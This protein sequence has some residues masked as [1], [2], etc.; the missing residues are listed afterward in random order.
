M[1]PIEREV[2]R[3]SRLE[4]CAVC[5]STEMLRSRERD[6]RDALTGSRQNPFRARIYSLAGFASTTQFPV[7]VASATPRYLCKVRRFAL[8]KEIQNQWLTR[9]ALNLRSAEVWRQTGR[10]REF[11][12]LTGSTQCGGLCA[13]RRGYSRF[14]CDKTRR[15]KLA[16]DGLAE[17]EELGSNG[18]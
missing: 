10:E 1:R 9:A 15:R 2:F 8:R 12:A 17:G 6:S 3:L 18:L 4:S 13:K 5:S 11:R 16:A 14:K 7:P